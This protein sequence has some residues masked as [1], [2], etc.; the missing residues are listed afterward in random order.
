SA[1]EGMPM[2]VLEALGCG[3]PVVTTRVGEVARVVHDGVS[4]YI[5][6][7][8]SAE[9]FADAAERALAALPAMT[10]EASVTAA[11][12]YVPARVLE[13]VFDNYRRIASH[14]RQQSRH[15]KEG[16]A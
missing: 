4:G 11:S 10:G 5:V 3:V 12:D 16:E 6:G 14:G 15:M 2:C 13:P 1:Y 9:S 7:D 8:R